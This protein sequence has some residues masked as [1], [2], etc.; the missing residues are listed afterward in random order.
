MGVVKLTPGGVTREFNQ[1]E[2]LVIEAKVVM[3]LSI[4]L[5]MT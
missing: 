1:I 2:A 3:S 4:A 5:S